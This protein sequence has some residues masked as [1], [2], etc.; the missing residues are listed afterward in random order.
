MARLVDKFRDE[1]DLLNVTG[2]GGV[3]YNAV[4]IVETFDDFIV[5]EAAEGAE[6]GGGGWRGGRVNVNIATITRLETVETSQ[7]VRLGLR[8]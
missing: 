7:K 3:H 5:I 2:N 1:G 6:R 4:R 8:G